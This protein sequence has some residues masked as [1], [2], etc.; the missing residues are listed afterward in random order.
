MASVCASANDILLNVEH[1]LYGEGEYL[2][3]QCVVDLSADIW[4]FVESC[5]EVSVGIPFEQDGFA[6]VCEHATGS[7]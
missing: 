4:R 6:D 2:L 1:H 7:T 3:R 5:W